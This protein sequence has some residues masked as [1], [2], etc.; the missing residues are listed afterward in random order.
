MI[1]TPTKRL[2]EID[3]LRGMAIILVLL[4]HKYLFPFTTNM[5]WIGVDLFF[6]LSG[7]LVSGLLF[8]EYL[9]FGDIHPKRFLIRRGFKIYPIYYLFYAFYLI[10]IFLADNFSLKGFLSDMLFVQNYVIGWGYAYPA[11]WSLAVEEHFYV[12]LSLILWW[13]IKYKTT[14]RMHYEKQIKRG[15]TAERI[16]CS[17][18][19]T[20]LIL[21]LASN[22][23]FPDQD[24][25]HTTMTH[26]R[27]D[28]L[29]AGVFISYLYYFKRAK[30]VSVFYTYKKRLFALAGIGLIWTPFIDPIPSFFVKTIGFTLLYVSFGIILIYFITT[31]RVNEHI[32]RIF[33]SVTVDLISKI[34]YCSYSIYV[35]HTLANYLSYEVYSNLNI[36]YNHYIDFL[37][38]TSASVICGMLMTYYVEDYF[39]K[40]RNRYFPSR[41]Q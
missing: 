28:S 19:C 9:R 23:M 26:L 22:L 11:S 30:L 39:L 4:R 13:G 33:G 40:I 20:C 8:K 21:R 2:R 10:P 31:P 25:R 24:A 27:M 16:L 29:I 38:A 7:F 6:T 41:V 17:I 36:A 18:L 14:N 5:G 12:G 1:T 15:L 37:L 34:G 32:N 3:F 35:I